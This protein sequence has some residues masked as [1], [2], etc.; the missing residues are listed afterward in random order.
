[1]IYYGEKKMNILTEKSGLNGQA[2]EG[3]E[4]AVIRVSI[5][6]LDRE[7]S[8]LLSSVIGFTHSLN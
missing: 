2:Y 7:N 8:W 4:R 1:V 3:I 6:M 5:E